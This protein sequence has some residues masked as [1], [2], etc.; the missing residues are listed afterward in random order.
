MR[1][2]FQ[3]WV[4]IWY[5]NQVHQRQ[6]D[7]RNCRLCLSSLFTKAAMQNHAASYATLVIH[8]SWCRVRRRPEHAKWLLM[9]IGHWP[10]RWALILKRWLPVGH[11]VTIAVVQHCL[12]TSAL[13]HRSQPA[14][15][16][17]QQQTVWLSAAIASLFSLGDGLNLPDYKICAWAQILQLATYPAM[18]SSA[19]RRTTN[20]MQACHTSTLTLPNAR[21]DWSGYIWGAE[22]LN[23]AIEMIWY[24]NSFTMSHLPD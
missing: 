3:W 12:L 24:V 17:K 4:R 1:C 15:L 20:S 9:E 5:G 21:F 10:V 6:K 18:T 23:I 14:Y 13:G 8:S 7:S 19:L 11:Q 22:L 16:T 2:P